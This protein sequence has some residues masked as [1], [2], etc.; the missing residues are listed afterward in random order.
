[1]IHNAYFILFTGIVFGAVFIWYY[2]LGVGFISRAHKGLSTEIMLFKKWFLLC[3][4]SGIVYLVV[5][6]IGFNEPESLKFLFSILFVLVLFYFVC[7]FQVFKRIAKAISA[8]EMNSE[9]SFGYYVGNLFLLW[10]FPIGIWFIQ[11]KAN[12]MI[13]GEAGPF[14]LNNT[15]ISQRTEYSCSNCGADVILGQEKCS[16]CGETLDQ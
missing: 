10:L 11:P 2:A 12:K 15:N 8:W 9:V 14:H 1:M 16:N 5:F 3:C 13:R 7:V 4:L 6:M